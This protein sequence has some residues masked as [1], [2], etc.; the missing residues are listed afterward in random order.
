MH[1]LRNHLGWGGVE[2][3]IACGIMSTRCAILKATAAVGKAEAVVKMEDVSPTETP[4][5]E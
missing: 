5:S 1:K 4:I 3:H 2:K